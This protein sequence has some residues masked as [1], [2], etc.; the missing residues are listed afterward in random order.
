MLNLAAHRKD[1]TVALAVALVLLLQAFF[2]AWTNGAMASG[3]MPADAWGN[4]ICVTSPDGSPSP[5]DGGV[6]IP[7]CCVL[8]C[9]MSSM[10][11]PQ[12]PLADQAV[13]VDLT[14][15]EVRFFATNPPVGTSRDHD[16]GS[17]RAPPLTA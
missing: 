14:G 13:R 8:G 10:A 4:P 6:N 2:T 12:P 9:T 7:N 1:R 17:P 5:A 11:I 16:P 15:T 3:I